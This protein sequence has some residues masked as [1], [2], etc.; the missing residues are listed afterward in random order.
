MLYN[1]IA[2]TNII[3][4]LMAAVGV[5]GILSKI[6]NHLTLHRLV[7]AA[8]NLSKSRHRL[9]ER[10]LSEYGHAYRTYGPVSNIL[11]FIRKYLYEY[12]GFLFRIHT[13]RQLE[14][15]TVWFSGILAVLGAATHYMAHGFCEG[16]FQYLA[17]GA[18]EM[19]TIS[20]ISQLSDEAYKIKGVETYLADYLDNV[21]AHRFLK[22]KQT[23]EPPRQK[24]RESAGQPVPYAAVQDEETLSEQ[25]KEAIRLILTEYLA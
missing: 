11:A 21:Y 10:I 15:Q 24:R 25:K 4:Y 7:K 2:D 22:E 14:T 9:M 5:I 20:V 12:R 23:E 19:I 18:A 6:I 1:V 8:G 3:F 16:M 13:W 17:V